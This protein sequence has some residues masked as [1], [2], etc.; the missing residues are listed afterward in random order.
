M[1]LEFIARSGYR[2]RCT[3]P[4]SRACRSSGFCATRRVLATTD[5]EH[6]RQSGRRIGERAGEGSGGRKSPAE[7]HSGTASGSRAENQIGETIGQADVASERTHYCSR[8]ILPRAGRRAHGTIGK[9]VNARGQDLAISEGAPRAGQRGGF[10]HGER[11]VAACLRLCN[12]AA[13]TAADA[14]KVG[15][16]VLAGCSG[17][18][19]GKKESD[20]SQVHVK[21]PVSTARFCAGDKRCNSFAVRV[22]R[23][24]RGLLFS[25]G[26]QT[27]RCRG[28]KCRR[29]RISLSTRFF[30]GL[31]RDWSPLSSAFRSSGLSPSGWSRGRYR[32]VS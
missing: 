18:E 2:K 12:G 30:P 29:I 26:E 11:P 28:V 17:D 20:W 22:T 14:D 27:Y 8:R 10:A 32:P 7:L 4:T 1:S 6:R 15:G 5:T 23:R 25:E 13:T 24:K 31:F 21:P 16:A 3:N 9:N 19:N